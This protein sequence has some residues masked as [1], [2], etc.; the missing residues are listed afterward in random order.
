MKHGSLFSGIGGFDLA[1]EWMGWENVFHCEWN[2]FGQKVLKHHFPNSKSYNDITKTDFSIHRGNIDIITGG[3][4]C[5]PYSTAGLRKGKADERHLF[6]EMLRAIKEI[7]PTWVIGENVRGLVS[8]GGDWCSTRCAMI[9]KGKDMKSNRFLFQ[10]QASTPRTKEKEYG[11]LPTPRTVMPIDSSETEVIGN[12]SIRKNGKM[13]GANLETLANR[14]LL[15]TPMAQDGKNSTLP[16]SQINRT[17]LVGMLC[18][19]TAQA[20]RGNTSHKRGKGNLTDQIAEMNLT[21][22]KTS[23]LNPQFVMEMMGFPT[24]WTLLPFLNG[25]TN[26][27]RQEEMQ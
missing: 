11:L 7:Q 12:R 17:S 16:P 1:A 23:Q 4:P 6:P 10:L 19:P 27:L 13:F 24:D 8:W 9:W 21:T 3:F 14:M 15:P 26:Q 25:E 2:P 18:T 22:S 20:S 5:Q